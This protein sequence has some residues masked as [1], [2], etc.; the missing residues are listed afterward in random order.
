MQVRTHTGKLYA[1]SRVKISYFIAVISEE[2]RFS[3]G[4]KYLALVLLRPDGFFYCGR[5]EGRLFKGI[6][7]WFEAARFARDIQVV[8][9]LRVMRLAA[10][11]PLASVEAWRMM[12]EKFVTLGEANW[13]VLTTLASGG[14]VRA[15]AGKNYALYRRRVRANRRRMGA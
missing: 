3:H 10:G 1:L 13:A 15:A 12:S 14:T 5:M 6:S 4:R 7:P 2:I 8:M 11:G 9:A